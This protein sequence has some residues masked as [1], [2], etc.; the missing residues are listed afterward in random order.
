MHFSS[1]NRSSRRSR[2]HFQFDMFFLPC[3]SFLFSWFRFIN[4]LIDATMFNTTI[5][6]RACQPISFVHCR[7]IQVFFLFFVAWILRWFSWKNRW[8]YK[9]PVNRTAIFHRKICDIHA[10]LSW[11][12]RTCPSL[13]MYQKRMM[14]GNAG[15]RTPDFQITDLTLYHLATLPLIA[16]SRTWTDTPSITDRVLYQLELWRLLILS[17]RR[18]LISQ[19]SDYRS[20]ALP[21]SYDGIYFKA[22]VRVELTICRFLHYKASCSLPRLPFRHVALFDGNKGCWSLACDS[23]D[24]LTTVIVYSLERWNG[25]GQNWTDLDWFTANRTTIY[26]TVPFFSVFVFNIYLHDLF[27]I[28]LVF[29]S[30]VEK[31]RDRSQRID[32]IEDRSI[33]RERDCLFQPSFRYKEYVSWRG[34]TWYTWLWKTFAWCNQGNERS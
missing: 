14:K 5:F 30:C 8:H 31:K 16:A 25:T 1:W 19:P 27:F 28:S 12:S 2:Q 10:I 18:V 20:V 4:L 29:K 24:R 22:T 3:S 26:P 33:K 17:H 21:L 23:G 32:I 11:K 6:A 15:N 13:K 7:K 34:A 9:N